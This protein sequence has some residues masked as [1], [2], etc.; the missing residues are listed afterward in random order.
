METTNLWS[1]LLD[2][3]VLVLLIATV[4]FAARLSSQ[5]AS[6]RQ[7]RKALETLIRDLSMQVD[8]A[9][10]SIL[11]L[12]HAAKDAGRDLQDLIDDASSYRD[13]LGLMNDTA[14]RVAARLEGLVDGTKSGKTTTVKEFPVT[15]NAGNKTGAKTKPGDKA[16]GFI[17]RDPDFG[18]DDDVDNDVMDPAVAMD[19]FEDNEGDDNLYSDA[20]RELYAALT[21]TKASNGGR[22]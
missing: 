21:K 19:G 6:F 5:L 9:E 3:A 7:S 13:E 1:L 16:P 11:G 17:I 22:S 8:K 18:R 20:E 12:K 14:D 10:S 2:G 15:G 4:A